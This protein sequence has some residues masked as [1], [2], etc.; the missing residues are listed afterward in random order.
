MDQM[1]VRLPHFHPK[2]T[3]VTLIGPDHGGYNHIS[4][5]AQQVGTIG[6]EIMTNISDRIPRVYLS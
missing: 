1:M 6:Y 4:D 5:I 3:P 2:G